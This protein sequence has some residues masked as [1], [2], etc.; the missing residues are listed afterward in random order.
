MA[1]A[2]PKIQDGLSRNR[3]HNVYCGEGFTIAI[4]SASGRQVQKP[5]IN[6]PDSFVPPEDDSV[7]QETGPRSRSSS[8]PPKDSTPRNRKSRSSTAS[9]SDLRKLLGRRNSRQ[10]SQS[11][12]DLDSNYYPA[13]FKDGRVRYDFSEEP[14]L[15]SSEPI[16]PV[17]VYSWQME[18]VEFAKPRSLEVKNSLQNLVI[19][20]LKST[21]F[22]QHTFHHLL[23][24]KQHP[25]H[26][27]INLQNPPEPKTFSKLGGEAIQID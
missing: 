21:E 23:K 16:P 7:S 26:H 27:Y 17:R 3:V 20:S 15:I 18:N 6:K 8:A 19:G 14:S 24:R 11:G 13:T 10:N 1:Y 12:E 2:I 25:V 4:T 5:I 22:H 9:S